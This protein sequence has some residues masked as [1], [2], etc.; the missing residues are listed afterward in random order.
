LPEAVW[1]G[2]CLAEQ[3][4]WLLHKTVSHVWSPGLLSWGWRCLVCTGAG[5]LGR[6]ELRLG[7]CSAKENRTCLLPRSLVSPQ[8]QPWLPTVQ[9]Q[10]RDIWAVVR[11]IPA[12]ALT[13][14]LFHT[15]TLSLFSKP[16][17]ALSQTFLALCAQRKQLLVTTQIWKKFDKQPYRGAPR[18]HLLP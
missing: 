15:C 4:A 3:G 13:L 5:W 6:G 14:K 7:V 9:T 1:F 10:T 8:S 18:R 12:H 11:R 16:L 2:C 17:T